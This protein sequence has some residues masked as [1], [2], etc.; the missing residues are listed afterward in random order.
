MHVQEVTEEPA[1]PT[2]Q[3]RVADQSQRISKFVMKK[4]TKLKKLF[5][6]FSDRSQLNAHK[7]RFVYKGMTLSGDETPSSINLKEGD[8]LEVFSS[9]VGGG[10]LQTPKYK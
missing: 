1:K 10:S 2:V 8:L 6:E 9:Q 5:K 3:I 4:N 7:L